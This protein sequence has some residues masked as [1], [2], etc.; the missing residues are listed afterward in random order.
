MI[1]IL[2]IL[3]LVVIIAIVAFGINVAAVIGIA[4]LCGI[5][6]TFAQAVGV[7]LALALVGNFLRSRAA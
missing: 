4:Y 1:R 5:P 3:A 6:L 2:A 7:A